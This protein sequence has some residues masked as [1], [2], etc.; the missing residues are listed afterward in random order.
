MRKGDIVSG[1][2]LIGLGI[3][4]IQEAF[5]LDYVNEYGPG[6]G[7]LPLWI[8]IGFL[9]LS[10]W[11]MITSLLLRR[12][13]Q[14]VEDGTWGQMGRVLGVWVGLAVAAAMLN[15][16]G[17]ILSFALLT[18]FLVLV[19]DRRPPLTAITVAVGAALCFYMIFVVGLGVQFPVGPW[20][21]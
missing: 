9:A 17:F 18:A 1:L 4:I 19:I 14:G 13:E 6:P 15:G 7:F 16:L 8:G 21:F 12:T 3:F 11:L 5:Q 10:S 20:G 2:I